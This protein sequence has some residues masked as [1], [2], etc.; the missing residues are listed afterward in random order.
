MLNDHQELISYSFSG[1]TWKF[2]PGVSITFS[3]PVN[4]GQT[5]AGINGTS[6][7]E[8]TNSYP[9]RPETKRS[10]CEKRVRRAC[11]R[12]GQPASSLEWE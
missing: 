5:E 1:L 7:A 8:V 9:L 2:H 4:S 3:Y 11:A 6:L 10:L 12:G